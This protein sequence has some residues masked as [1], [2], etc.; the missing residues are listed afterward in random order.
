M[1][2][3]SVVVLALS[4]PGAFVVRRRAVAEADRLRR[5]AAGLVARRARAVLGLTALVRLTG[6]VP[7]RLV[8]DVLA[9]FCIKPF[10]VLLPPRFGNLR[11]R[12]CF[13][14]RVYPYRSEEMGV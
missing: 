8:M 13:S 5:R 11:F 10:S 6:L 14:N 9:R 12:E 7:L 2:S 4:R 3:R 1:A